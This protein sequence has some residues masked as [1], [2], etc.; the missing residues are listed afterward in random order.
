MD[1]SRRHGLL[2]DERRLARDLGVPVVPTVAR[3][4]EGFDLLLQTLHEVA[5]GR[6]VCRPRRLQSPPAELKS[7]IERV[8]QE[9]EAAF[10][11]LPNP[12]W[13]ALRLLDGDERII[14]SVRQR[15][16]ADLRRPSPAE[17]APGLE[18]AG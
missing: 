10:P 14:Q 7:A 2:V 8:T 18:G 16:L 4:R 5:S 11:G 13:V 9:V 6:T 3:T 12:R 17:M 1:E 15:E